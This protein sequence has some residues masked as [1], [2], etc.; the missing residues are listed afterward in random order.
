MRE[1]RIQRRS[2]LLRARRRLWTWS[3]KL[4]RRSWHALFATAS[5]L[6]DA[7]LR[8]EAREVE[9]IRDVAY[10]AHPVA[11]T[12][13]IYRPRGVKGPLPVMLYIHG[14]AFTICSK[15]T[16]RGIALAKAVGS[17][18]LVFNINYR[19]APS[20]P[21]PAA[22]EDACAAYRWVVKHA[23]R[24]GGDPRRIVVAGESAGG[25]L[26]LGVAVAAT[27]RRPEPYAKAVYATRVVPVAVMPI[28]PY[29]QASEPEGRDGG[30][31]TR[32]VARDIAL[33]YLGEG[34]HD[35]QAILMA[36]PIRVLEECGA[37]QRRFP[38]V[39]SGVGTRD[40]CTTDVRRLGRAC[41]RL[42]IPATMRYYPGEVHAFHALRWRVAAQRF[43]LEMFRFMQ[44]AALPA[45]RHTARRIAKRPLRTLRKTVRVGRRA[46]RALASSA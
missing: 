37:P 42:G 15:D 21:F 12:L 28:C 1:A 20:H 45:A 24:Y 25:N 11:H 7:S 9:V 43:W 6:A 26:A 22:I 44:D 13:D 33:M 23:R 14:G 10:G 18:Y 17:Q 16:H 35:P 30:F 5:R 32:R 41:R 3:V 46:A 40:I 27:Y 8:R 29:L 19:L 39:L 36:D 31:L 4:Q 2:L 38:P 34:T